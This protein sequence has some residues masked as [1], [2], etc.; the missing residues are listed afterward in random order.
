M[1]SPKIG[2]LAQI[3]VLRAVM[4]SST[5]CDEVEGEESPEASI[6]VVGNLVFFARFA[7]LKAF[8]LRTA[9][10]ETY[11][12]IGIILPWI[13]PDFLTGKICR[14]SQKAILEVL[15]NKSIQLT[16]NRK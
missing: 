8:T 7:R 9:A 14:M 4:I 11:L 6:K 2:R 12:T 13:V 3:A 5:D 16:I 1:I 10:K 15:K